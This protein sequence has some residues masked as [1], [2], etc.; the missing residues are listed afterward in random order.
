MNVQKC[1]FLIA[2]IIETLIR[3]INQQ[4][5]PILQALENLKN[6]IDE[7]LKALKAPES[8]FEDF[9]QK[10]DYQKKLNRL[11]DSLK[12]DIDYF[13]I[14]FEKNSP[15]ALEGN[16]RFKKDYGIDSMQATRD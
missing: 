1:L 6:E 15:Q 7:A 8:D 4:D 9:I 14:N 2:F 10:E 3:E 12:K 16:S 13:K 5:S 11:T